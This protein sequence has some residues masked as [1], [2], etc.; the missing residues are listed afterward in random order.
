[1]KKVFL[2]LALSALLFPALSVLFASE[3]SG[4]DVL[5]CW[6][7]TRTGKMTC[8]GAKSAQ[9]CVSDGGRVVSN[10]NQCREE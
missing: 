7:C 9:E 5:C 1:M 2:V 6:R 8:V 4:G 3:E 10:C